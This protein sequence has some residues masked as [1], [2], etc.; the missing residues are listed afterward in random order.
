MSVF[1]AKMIRLANHCSII[2]PAFEKFRIFL[3]DIIGNVLEIL[4]QHNFE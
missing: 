1:K 3:E 4:S 2:G